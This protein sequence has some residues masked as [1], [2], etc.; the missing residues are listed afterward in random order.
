M[1]RSRRGEGAAERVGQHAQR[2]SLGGGIEG[3]K[4]LLRVSKL[5]VAQRADAEHNEQLLRQPIGQ[6][7]AIVAERERHARGSAV[8]NVLNF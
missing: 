2:T 4:E 5:G 7:A 1:K 8:E 3:P 6:G